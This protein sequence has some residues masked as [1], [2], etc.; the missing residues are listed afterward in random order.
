MCNLTP[1]NYDILTASVRDEKELR[2]IS[3]SITY[4]HKNGNWKRIKLE[5]INF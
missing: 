1:I 5:D 3:F 4:I 2:N